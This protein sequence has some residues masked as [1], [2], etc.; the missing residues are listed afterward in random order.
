MSNNGYD[1][2]QKGGSN[3]NTTYHKGETLSIL[4]SNISF[5][6]KVKG[7]KIVKKETLW[8]CYYLATGG[9]GN[10][11]NLEDMVVTSWKQF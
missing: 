3:G 7:V 4:K 5:A 8:V 1:V 11:A 10:S 9:V 2:T 6:R